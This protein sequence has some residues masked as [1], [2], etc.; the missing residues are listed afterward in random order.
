M[1]VCVERYD[2]YLVGRQHCLLHLDMNLN[3]ELQTRETKERVNY[4]IENKLMPTLQAKAKVKTCG[5]DISKSMS[6]QQTKEKNRGGS[7]LLLLNMETQ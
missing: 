5:L 2:F 4:G 1:C 3:R 6:F 7:N